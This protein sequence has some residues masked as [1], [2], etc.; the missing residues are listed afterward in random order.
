[1]GFLVHK[2]IVDEQN[3][4][5]RREVVRKSLDRSIKMLDEMI[6][7]TRKMVF[8]NGNERDNCNTGSKNSNENKRV[9]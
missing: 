8:D 9:E 6:L 4:R 5:L 2:I 3:E 1:M 7:N